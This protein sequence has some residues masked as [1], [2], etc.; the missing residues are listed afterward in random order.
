MS[1]IRITQ[2]QIDDGFAEQGM[3]RMREMELAA[4]RADNIELRAQVA[5]AKLTQRNERRPMVHVERD[6]AIVLRL[7]GG[8]LPKLKEDAVLAVQQLC[9]G[10]QKQMLSKLQI[11]RST[12]YKHLRSLKRSGVI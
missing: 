7:N 8:G 2:Q 1:R 11:G 3:R 6:D 9:G 4:F 10:N 12:L 5:I